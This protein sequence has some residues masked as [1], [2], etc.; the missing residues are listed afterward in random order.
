L[1]IIKDQR[2]IGPI[3]RIIELLR[4]FFKNVLKDYYFLDLS[5][6]KFRKISEYPEEAWLEAVVNALAHRSYNLHGNVTL[7]KH[8]DDR[9]EI[10]NS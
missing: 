4:A 5:E 8:F 7:I 9:L 6:G 2:F 10:S 3:P 1:N